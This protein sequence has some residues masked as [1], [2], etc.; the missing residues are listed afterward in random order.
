M[1][2]SRE[3][4]TKADEDRLITMAAQG[5]TDRQIADALRR[6]TRAISHRRVLLGIKKTEKTEQT[7]PNKS[8]VSGLFDG[9]KG[10]EESRATE[11][12]AEEPE[13]DTGDGS[14][15]L[16]REIRFQITLTDALSN[17]LKAYRE[18]VEDNL[19]TVMER[20]NE[21][22][23]DTT[24]MRDAAHGLTKEVNT[25]MDRL[26]IVELWL[27]QSRFYRLTHSFRRFAEAHRED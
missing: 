20:T 21:L 9:T 22:S 26:Y 14:T 12:E 16:E 1:S 7:E 6:T 5:K 2:T 4:W 24:L 13:D 19:A 15:E 23:K 27:S 8:G 3:Y 17:E 10:A 25:F 18:Q 11:R